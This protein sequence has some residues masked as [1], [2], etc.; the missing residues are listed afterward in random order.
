MLTTEGRML[1]L[2]ILPAKSC[3]CLLSLAFSRLLSCVFVPD[4]YLPPHLSVFVPTDASFTRWCGGMLSLMK[5][6][7]LVAEFFSRAPFVRQ[8]GGSGGGNSLLACRSLS[9]TQSEEASRE[10]EKQT[11]FFCR[12]RST[13]V[14]TFQCTSTALLP[15]YFIFV[16]FVGKCLCVCVF[17]FVP[18]WCVFSFSGV[19][20]ECF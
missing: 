18:F 13:S 20:S 10:N 11:F 8:H 6:P 17:F 9:C 3:L 14:Q 7:P 12:V 1:L 2:K 4:M 16:I 15:M 19:V 5:L